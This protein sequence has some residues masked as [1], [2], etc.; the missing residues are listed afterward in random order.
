MR[1]LNL[2]PAGYFV[3]YVDRENF[4]IVA[5]YYRNIINAN[6]LACDPETGRV[7]PCDGSYKPKPYR[8]YRFV[9]SIEYGFVSLSCPCPD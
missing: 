1:P 4:L 9:I 5:Q 2:D 6:G 7:I 8:T 3:I